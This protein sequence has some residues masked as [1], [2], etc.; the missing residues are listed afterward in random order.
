MH[1]QISIRQRVLLF[2]VITGILLILWAYTSIP[3]S[4]LRMIRLS[5]YSSLIS[6]L[7]LYLSL[8]ISP[9]YTFWP[10][11][12]WKPYLVKAR[13]AIGVSGWAFGLFHSFIGFFGQLSGIHGLVFL[14]SQYK[15]ALILGLSALFL[16]TLLAITSTKQAIQFFQYPRWKLLHRSTYIASFAV[17]VHALMLGTHFRNVSDFIPSLF[18]FLL[19]VLLCMEAYR[20]IVWRTN[21]PIRSSVILS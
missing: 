16:F 11:L 10:E 6:I 17:V 3:I 5:E 21:T 12:P 15:S 9:L 19:F 13:R 7:F 8:I 1:R 14:S 4:S 18:L 2:S 20:F